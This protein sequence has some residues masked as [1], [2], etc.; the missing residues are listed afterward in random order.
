MKKGH[1]VSYTSY[2][3]VESIGTNYFDKDTLN[4]KDLNNENTYQ[5]KGKALIDQLVSA[6]EYEKEEKCTKTQLAEKFALVGSHPFTVVFEKQN[7]DLR[8]LRG[9]MLKVE[10]GLGRSNVIDLDLPISD[11][12]KRM[13]QVDHRTLKSLIVNGVKYILKK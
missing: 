7:G 8:T 10:N 12:A 1:I 9:I 6:D 13:R 5:M 4:L 11:K 3:K 2:C